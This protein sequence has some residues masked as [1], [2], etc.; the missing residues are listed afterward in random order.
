MA[1]GSRGVCVEV[2]AALQEFWA[3]PAPASVCLR[4]TVGTS[5]SLV[6]GACV[7]SMVLGTC[8]TGITGFSAVF[9]HVSPTLAFQTSHGFLLVL[10]WSQAFHIVVEAIVYQ[11]VGCFWG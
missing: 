9:G 11:F 2:M 1:F 5:E 6:G 4:V 8:P 7:R 3:L 10:D